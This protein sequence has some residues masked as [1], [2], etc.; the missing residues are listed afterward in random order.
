M[1][2]MIAPYKRINDKK[3]N[4]VIG[5]AAQT[6]SIERPQ[7]LL[8][9][10][11]TDA[12]LQYAQQSKSL[13]FVDLAILNFG[14]IRVPLPQ[15]DI[16]LGKVYEILPFDN[17]LVIITLKGIELQKIFDNFTY[18]TNQACANVQIVYHNNKPEKILVGG[19][20]I[21]PDSSYNIVTIDYIRNG[22]DNIL[23]DVKQI[24]ESQVIYTGIVMRDIIVNKIKLL[25]EQGRDVDAV[26]D[27]RVIVK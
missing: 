7:S 17:T 3:M 10:F 27:N 21:M 25:K 19:Q 23:P 2:A 14:G 5:Y 22:G 12:I 6:M 26:L 4:V 16:T 1:I 9:N 18:T 8:S 13:P 20:P 15:G 24:K 11:C